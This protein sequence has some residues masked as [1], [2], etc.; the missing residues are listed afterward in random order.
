MCLRAAKKTSR[1]PP[2]EFLRLLAERRLGGTE[3]LQ[4]HVEPGNR[5]RME[6]SCGA[7]S[8]CRCQQPESGFHGRQQQFTLGGP[9]L[10]SHISTTGPAWEESSAP[11]GRNGSLQEGLSLL[12]QA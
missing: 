10:A 12:L 4:N 2:Q 9:S 8:L 1:H 3:A 11:F 5:L 7:Q 6:S